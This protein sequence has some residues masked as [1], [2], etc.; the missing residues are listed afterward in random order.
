MDLNCYGVAAKIGGTRQEGDEFE[1][2]IM[3]DTSPAVAFL[4]G[5][6]RRSTFDTGMRINQK[7]QPWSQ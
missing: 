7:T 4:R 1:E 2:L 3:I 6:T 5:K